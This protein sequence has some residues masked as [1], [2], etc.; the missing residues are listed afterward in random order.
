MQRNKTF[1]INYIRAANY[2]IINSPDKIPNMHLY[3]DR[4]CEKCRATAQCEIFVPVSNVQKKVADLD[5]GDYRQTLKN[6][7]KWAS[8]NQIRLEEIVAGTSSDA[9]RR[10]KNK[11]NPRTNETSKIAA[12]YRIDSMNFKSKN[13]D[14]FNLFRQSCVSRAELDPN[15]DRTAEHTLQQAFEIIGWYELQMPLKITRAYLGEYELADEEKKYQETNGSAKVVLTA[16]ER[17]LTAWET[18]GNYFPELD[19]DCKKFLIQLDRIRKRILADF[20]NALQYIR[21]GIDEAVTA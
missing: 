13:K 11:K 1:K 7:A 17:S 8:D 12:D 20:P 16:I 5:L 14:K 9:E 15:A 18:I 3:C 19:N 21:P 10:E 2:L 4:W 6:L